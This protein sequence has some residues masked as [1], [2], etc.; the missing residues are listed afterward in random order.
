MT[1]QVAEDGTIRLIGHCPSEDAEPLLQHLRGSPAADVDWQAC[2]SAHGAVIQVLV[3]AGRRVI[4]PPASA[5][6]RDWVAPL[7]GRGPVD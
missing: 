1:I 3:V 6:L 7:L 4:G 2:E 5:A